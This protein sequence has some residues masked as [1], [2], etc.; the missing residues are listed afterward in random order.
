MKTILDIIDYCPDPIPENTILRIGQTAFDMAVP[1]LFRLKQPFAIA[2]D[3]ILDSNQIKR[4][5]DTSARRKTP[6][7]M[8]GSLRTLPA[9]A[10]LKEI[11]S[12][13]RLGDIANIIAHIPNGNQAIHIVDAVAWL[14]PNATVILHSQHQATIEIQGSVANA[15][16]KINNNLNDA[17]I[18]IASCQSTKTFKVDYANPHDAEIHILTRT[19]PNKSR[20]IILKNPQDQLNAIHLLH[21][22][23]T[24]TT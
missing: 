23:T 7:A 13:N 17:T 2:H 21:A 8:L 22:A 10:K 15:K 9:F 11:V 14:D 4:L 6:V 5:A 3:C 18:E 12:S 20:W 16:L 1:Q 24:I 19:T